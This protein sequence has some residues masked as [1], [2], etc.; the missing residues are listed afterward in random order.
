MVEAVFDWLTAT[1]LVIL[2]TLFWV[3]SA[4]AGII[5]RMRG[6]RRHRMQQNEAADSISKCEKQAITML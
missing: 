5:E 4:V 2:G 6:P 3:V 1:V